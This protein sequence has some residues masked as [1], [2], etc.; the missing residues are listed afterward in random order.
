M[1]ILTDDLSEDFFRSMGCVIASTNDLTVRNLLEFA[2]CFY[3]HIRQ[4]NIADLISHQLDL[5]IEVKKD[6]FPINILVGQ[7]NII[8]TV[9]LNQLKNSLEFHLIHF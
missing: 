4:Q 8:A 1:F 9:K 7:Y 5:K 6:P 2:K 3:I